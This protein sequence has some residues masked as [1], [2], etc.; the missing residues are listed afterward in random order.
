[1]L[2]TANGIYDVLERLEEYSS[3]KLHLRH[4]KNDPQK[5]AEFVQKRP[6]FALDVKEANPGKTLRWFVSD[7]ARVGQ[8]GILTRVWART[9]TRPAMVGNSA[10][11]EW[12]YL[13]AAAD[14]FSGDAIAMVTPTVNTGL[15]QTF[16]QWIV[17]SHQARSEPDSLIL[18]LDNTDYQHRQGTGFGRVNDRADVPAARTVP[19]T[20]QRREPLAV[21][22]EPAPLCQPNL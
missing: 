15:M 22:A 17:R 6:L 13:W 8:K 5:A 3:L 12:V 9:G 16:A 1:M 19:R 7:E 14:P 10:A 20:R 4:Q 2:Y 18:V 21:A 11:Y